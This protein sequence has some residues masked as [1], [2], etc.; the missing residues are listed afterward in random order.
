[1]YLRMESGDEA[2]LGRRWPHA[3]LIAATDDDPYALIE[4]AVTQA[5]KYSG[6]A[7]PLR[8]KCLPPSIDTFAW[9]SWDAF[10][11]SVSAQGLMDGIRS[12]S[13]GGAP[14]KTVII[15]DG[16][17]STDLDSKFRGWRDPVSAT[18]ASAKEKFGNLSGSMDGPD[19]DAAAVGGGSGVGA[20]ALSSTLGAGGGS[21]ERPRDL[22]IEGESEAISAV[23]RDVP[24]GTATGQ[25]LQEVK[26][27]DD[28][29]LESID[30]YTMARQH[31][32]VGCSPDDEM[33]MTAPTTARRRRGNVITRASLAVAQYVAGL[34]VGV[35]QA[36]IIL[37]YQWVVDPA[38]DGAW[39][40][41]FFSF[42][43]S[44]PL[45]DP[46]LQF[47]ADQT[48]FTRRLVDIRANSKFHGPEASPEAI[49]SGKKE[50]LASVI[51]H[52]R[53]SLAIEYIYC[54]HGLSA[55]W[56][57]VCPDAPA[58]KKYRPKIVYARPPPSLREIEPSMSWNP[59]VLGGLGAVYDPAPLFNDMHQYLSESGVTGVKVD[60]QAGVG[61]V[62]SVTGGGPFVAARYHAALED[63]VAKHF[64]GN[65][66]INC[67]CHSTEN[68]Y[69]WRDT[70]VA[71]ASDDFFPT[72]TASH[73][74]HVAACAFNGLFI[75]ALALPDFD[76]FQ[77]RHAVAGLHAAARAVS[78]G[79]VYV[80]DAPGHHNFEI[81]HQLVLPDGGVLR[82]QLPGRPT[83]D[84]LFSDVL[85]DGQSLLKIWNINPMTGVVGVFNVQG[86]SWNRAF[87]R[88]AFHSSN[89]PRLTTTV[90]VHDVE[91]LRHQDVVAGAGN[92]KYAAKN[93]V[94]VEEEKVES[95]LASENGHWGGGGAA[96]AGSST[97][98]TT[99]TA[100][101]LS[102]SNGYAS[103]VSNGS[104]ASDSDSNASSSTTMDLHTHGVGTTNG[105]GTEGKNEYHSNGRPVFRRHHRVPTTPSPS[106]DYVAFTNTTDTLT[107]LEPEGG[108]EV[109]L[110]GG[111]A[112][113][114]TF[115]RISSDFGVEFAPIGL[116]NMLNGGG[117]V[118]Y[119]DVEPDYGH[120]GLTA[121]LS[122]SG[123]ETD[124]YADLVAGE[125]ATDFEDGSALPPVL[126]RFTVGVR[127]R[128]TLV[129][130]CSREPVGCWVDGYEV[131]FSWKLNES[132][133]GGV[134]V[135]VGRLEIDV[136]QV[137]KHMEQK[138]VVQFRRENGQYQ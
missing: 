59:S 84:C 15:D 108:V 105:G 87:R 24:A 134:G 91:V 138:V 56:S 23:L 13:A 90:R 119:V 78:G 137:G 54:W 4:A 98:T 69:R 115:A 79:P 86:S 132:E 10:Y 32:A 5:A 95:S 120:P 67:M 48:N 70:A 19:H 112:A 2:V 49:H 27:A 114:V 93:G 107:R 81:L 125:L 133:G 92:A 103:D 8:D 66:A 9:C 46:M 135:G 80:S 109:A 62:G 96:L 30:Y 63:S 101:T 110:S 31:D 68:I 118:Q 3:L 18:L 83:R 6:T 111:H 29:S 126:P 102:G 22:Y 44:G 116:K 42:L 88:F 131:R 17:Q 113:I 130:L 14:P 64:P 39:P 1:M 136:P 16:W 121:A 123:T 65:D 25:L 82:A 50:N 71:R 45:R 106:G 104:G 52:M 28:P 38:A 94:V 100:S 124:R 129:A 89:V 55:Y 47:Y 61:M 77:S 122:D 76:M 74:P 12:L 20:D 127:G 117:A 36:M 53:E 72:D 128:G 34:V 33:A 35:F 43:A 58:M 99:T 11:S 57:G 73:L 37:F 75:S 51:A 97:T 21:K 85:R 26:A 40:V 60:C 7:K 41:R